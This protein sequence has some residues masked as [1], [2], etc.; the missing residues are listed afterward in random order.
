VTNLSQA[1]G[2]RTIVVEN[3]IDAAPINKYHILVGLLGASVL[4]MDGYDA[5]VMGY[6]TPQLAKNWDIPKT[7]IG[8]IFSSGLTGVLLGQLFI[9][10]LSGRFGTKF[11]IVLC[12]FLFGAL[13]M[14]TT[15]APSVNALIALRFLT[16]LGLGGAQP[17]ASAIIGEFCPKKWR[18]TFIVFGNCG[19]T[20]GSMLAGALSALLL[21]QYGW[22][23]VL[24]AG[25]ALPVIFS[26]ILLFALPESLRFMLTREKIASSTIVRL[27][28][29]AAPNA[30]VTISDRL[31]IRET[32]RGSW[33]SLFE[34]ARVLGTL[35][36]WFGFFANLMVYFFVQNWLA[37]MLIDAGHDQ[38]SAILVAS[39][40]QVGGL[41]AAFFIGPL[42][43][44]LNPFFVLSTYFVG[45]AVS[46][47]TM[48]SASA[49]SASAASIVAFFVGF[50]LL[51]INKGLAAISVDFYPIPLRAAGLGAGLG[52][53][54]AGAVISP[55]LAGF[56]LS[57]GWKAGWLFYLS[58]GPMVISCLAFLLASRR[59]GRSEIHVGT[60]EV[61]QA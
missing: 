28:D 39:A 44:K 22:E 24:W 57:S 43:D 48:A 60:P 45:G 49:W 55:L 38:Q 33:A 50:F 19:V 58:A 56:L 61:R 9:A 53:G 12:T 42:M 4:F 34:H 5:Q 29:R 17:L 51:G 30:R 14:L 35:V 2:A 27:L 21:S 20:L 11:M 59:Y 1:R 31:T 3:E 36:L 18:S 15:V 46:L 6:I 13:T 26:I 16:G 25:G 8:L 10:P 40:I 54:R 47:V 32:E 41:V 23:P 7:E 37:T 52:V